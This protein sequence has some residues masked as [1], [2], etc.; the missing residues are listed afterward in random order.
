MKTSPSRLMCLTLTALAV[1]M[2][3]CNLPASSADLT[4]TMNVTQAYETVSA[5]LTQ[6]ALLT[7]PAAPSPTPAPTNTPEATPTAATPSPIPSATQAA[8]ANTCD[9]AAPGAPIDVTIPDDTQMAPGQ[10]FTKVWRL[11]NAGTCTWTTAYTIAVFSGEAMSAP[12]SVALPKE[13]PPGQEVD[14]AVDLVAP[15][16]PGTY[17]SNWKLRNASG[18]WFGI[19][20]GGGSPFWVKIIVS[21]NI[22]GTPPTPAATAT[23][24][25]PVQASGVI[26]LALNNTLNLDNN[27][28]NAGAGDDLSYQVIENQFV[29]IPFNGAMFS[30]WG[31]SQPT[32]N[33]C[34]S[35]SMSNA[36]LGVEVVGPN[37]YVCYKTD[38]GLIG[39]FVLTNFNKTENTL[40]LQFLTWAQP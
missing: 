15:L 29:L 3:S 40:T 36:A 34:L 1:L 20:P 8:P 38:L 10:A 4:P 21:G 27:Q 7:P 28:I 23:G 12:Q 18:A 5:N 16:T 19:G 14:I 35:A 22:T 39:W 13:V 24:G 25:P 2:S 9:L 17:Y 26:I 33:D 32:R 6:A 11:K 31:G 30:L 37:R